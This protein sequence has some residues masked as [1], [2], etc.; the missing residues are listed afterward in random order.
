M[1]GLGRTDRQMAKESG[2]CH[3]MEFQADEIGDK[4]T[5]SM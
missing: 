5:Q 2:G 1:A 4:A 3:D